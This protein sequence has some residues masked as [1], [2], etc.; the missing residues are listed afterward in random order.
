M[1]QLRFPLCF[2][3]ATPETITDPETL[4]LSN[5]VAQQP[6]PEKTP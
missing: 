3:P 4:K 2:R 5:T 6:A 1:I